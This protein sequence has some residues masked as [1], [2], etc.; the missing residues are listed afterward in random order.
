MLGKGHVVTRGRPIIGGPKKAHAD[1]NF[2][3]L[4]LKKYIFYI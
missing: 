4:Y 3:I 1:F 2:F